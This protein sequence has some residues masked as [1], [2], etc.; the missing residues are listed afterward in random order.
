MYKLIKLDKTVDKTIS[1]IGY[2]YS[3]SVGDCIAIRF[4]DNTAV[5]LQPVQ[6]TYDDYPSVIEKLD[7]DLYD[8]HNANLITDEEYSKFRLE[9]EEEAKKDKQKRDYK[10]Y[11]KLKEKFEND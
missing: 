10:E 9:K 1:G 8:L 7:L 3:Y 4:T 11:L 2:F 6:E 5:I